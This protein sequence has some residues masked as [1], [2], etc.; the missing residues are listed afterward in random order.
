MLQRKRLGDYLQVRTS[1][2]RHA[3][4][5]IGKVQPHEWRARVDKA[6]QACFRDWIDNKLSSYPDDHQVPLKE[7]LT[8]GPK[9]PTYLALTGDRARVALRAKV[10]FLRYYHDRKGLIPPCQWCGAP[11]GEL[12]HHLVRCS[13]M[14]A[15]CA[16]LLTE[17][18]AALRAVLRHGATVSDTVIT[19]ALVGME[20]GGKGT[21]DAGCPPRI[22]PC[23]Q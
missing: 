21:F 18:K 14:P 19:K 13:A 11:A 4:E 16:G 7:A 5:G 6:I 22:S 17:A 8:S 1:S 12:A 3:L 20:W 10:P 9:R 23:D 2:T 15:S